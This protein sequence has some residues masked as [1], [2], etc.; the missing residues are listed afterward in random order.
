MSVERETNKHLKQIGDS[1]KRI[2]KHLR[3]VEEGE[4]SY[5]FQSP[6]AGKK[7]KSKGGDEK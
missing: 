6:T 2:E 3:P 1:L 5:D 4:D 7:V